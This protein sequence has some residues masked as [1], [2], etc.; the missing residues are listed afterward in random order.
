[1]C[2][3]LG[4]FNL[5]K[6]AI[7]LESVAIE[8]GLSLLKH[9]GP[10]ASGIWISE[11]KK[12]VFG[13]R[14]LSIIDLSESAN[15][16]MTNENGH[17]AIVFNGEIYNFPELR[18]DLISK[19]H[20]FKSYSDTEVI[21]HGYEEYEIDILKKINGMFAFVIYDNH[22]K[23][24]FFARDRLGKK[25]LYFIHHNHQFIF[26][27]EIAPIFVVSRTFSKR[28]KRSSLLE[29]LAFNRVYAPDT[30]FEGIYKLPAA[31]YGEIDVNGEF[32][33]KE[34]WT[35]YSWLH[36]FPDNTE[37]FYE[38][39]IYDEF[40]RSVTSRL[41]SD[42]PLG[43]FLSGG[44]DSSGITAIAF[45]TLGPGVKTFTAGFEGQESYDETSK[46]RYVSSLFET[47]HSEFFITR[48]TILNELPKLVKYLDDPIADA[49]IV[50]IYFLSQIARENKV[51]VILNGDGADELFS[52]YNKWLQYIKYFPIWK[53]IKLIPKPVL[54][55][56]YK[57]FRTLLT[58]VQRDVLNR[59][60]IGTQYFI[61]DT[62]A[63]KGTDFFEYSIS[64]SVYE[65][66]NERFKEFKKIQRSDNY[67]EWL[68]YWGLKSACEHLFLHRADRMGMANSIEIRNPYLDYRLVELAIQMPQDLKI[69]NGIGKYILKR[70]F[71]KILPKELL[72][73]QKQGFCVPINGWVDR[74]QLQEIE[75]ILFKIN[76]D[77]EIFDKLKF[78][79]FIDDIKDGKFDS[80]ANIVL[81]LYILSHWYKTW[82]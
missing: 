70:S 79:R 67:I 46:A 40:E 56:V 82:F 7:G 64:N 27:S 29:Y 66:I 38:S 23:K 74:T 11:D 55:I 63:L 2:G 53:T 72:Y 35:P 37:E 75:M 57:S 71:E 13:H 41:I 5:K 34:Y 58:Q 36:K 39:L 22:K 78:S 52:G 76:Q 44:V 68:S 28:I 10:D 54:K 73:A 62:G 1:M 6:E 60:I 15:Q 69:R 43:I 8:S 20:L 26:S 30:L 48:Q 33:I 24:L 18:K 21:L 45:K 19:G 14:R 9:R 77:F 61:G 51:V 49:T 16:P 17:I 80:N 59:A 81:N 3:L 31:H 12:V 4:I 50:P 25:P 42:V 32:K 65:K 47:E